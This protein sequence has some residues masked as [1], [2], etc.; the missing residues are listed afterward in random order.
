[1]EQGTLLKR[2]GIEA[3]ALAL[4][5]VAPEDKRAGIAAALVRLV[6]TGR[7]NM[8]TLFKAMAISAPRSAD[9][10]GFAA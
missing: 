2:L 1:V 6:G 7:A 9:L 8:G 3:R 10:P 5:A 4:Q